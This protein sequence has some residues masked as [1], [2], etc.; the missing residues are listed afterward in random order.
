[1]TRKRLYQISGVILTQSGLHVGGSE[2]ELEIGGI[3]LPVIKTPETEIPYI[4]GSSLKGRMRAE[5][6]RVLDKYS[7]DKR[8]PC[9]C[10]QPAC[11]VCRVFGPHKYKAKKKDA[12]RGRTVEDVS[13]HPGP[14]RLLVRDAYAPG[15]VTT[16]LKTENVIDRHTGQAAHPRKYERVPPHVSFPFRLT[17]QVM[18]TDAN[19]TF[20]DGKGK[21]HKAGAALLAVVRDC[22]GY[23]EQT[24]IGG[25]LSRG[26]GQ[27]CF[28]DLKVDGK[29]V[30]LD[31]A[32]W[33]CD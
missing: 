32:D 10:C 22:L 16:E 4:P 13:N 29:D 25:S 18:D 30:K 26:S 20:T 6:E 31:D 8:E 5:L 33:P 17:L 24:G 21:S 14:T 2:D 27:I 9:N 28:K 15:P 12:G 1:M 3:D 19:F 23:V 11:P 7:N